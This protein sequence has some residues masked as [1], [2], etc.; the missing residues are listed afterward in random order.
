M[1]TKMLLSSCRLHAVSHPFCVLAR[2]RLRCV[3]PSDPCL[4][5]VP[6]APLLAAFLPGDTVNS[7]V[8]LPFLLDPSVA[9]GPCAPSLPDWVRAASEF[10]RAVG[11]GLVTAPCLPSVLRGPWPPRLLPPVRRRG[12]YARWGTAD[13]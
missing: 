10:L 13:S 7:A 2:P 4:H 12:V 11:T 5:S 8:L 3:P 9:C 6:V 1:T